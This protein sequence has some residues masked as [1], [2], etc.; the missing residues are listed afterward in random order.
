MSLEKGRASVT[1]RKS[2][3]GT[4]RDASKAARRWPRGLAKGAGPSL[5]PSFSSRMRPNRIHVKGEKACRTQESDAGLAATSSNR[6]ASPAGT[7]LWG[8]RIFQCHYSFET[9]TARW[10]E[11]T[12]VIAMASA[13]DA[14][15]HVLQRPWLRLTNEYKAG[16]H[17]FWCWVTRELANF[18]RYT[19]FP[20]SQS[21][22]AVG[23]TPHTKLR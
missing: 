15:G 4:T 16:L 1:V 3:T 11:A 14:A 7:H 10:L 17:H 2:I 13:S 5:Q 23:P 12:S 20:C 9:V 21:L 6:S 8:S 18:D 19:L 22:F